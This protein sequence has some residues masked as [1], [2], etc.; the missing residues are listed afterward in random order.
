MAPP[1]HP[2]WGEIEEV[3]DREIEAAL[4]ER[5]TPAVAV[6]DAGAGI[7]GL[8]TSEAMP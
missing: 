3:L 2:R 4:Y 5:K 8:L 6:K 7:D 1:P